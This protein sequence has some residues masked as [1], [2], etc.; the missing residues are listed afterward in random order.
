LFTGGG[1]WI[2]SGDW[3]DETAPKAYLNYILFDENF[4]LVDFGFDQVS[5]AAASGHEYIGLHVKVQQKGYLYVYLSNE[6]AVQTN[7]Y[8]D[9]FEILYHSAVEQV[10]DYYPFGYRS[11]YL[12]V[13]KG[14]LM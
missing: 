9:D 8:F 11:K 4:V 10:D 7:V 12:F 5:T 1:P 3:E 13:R 14:S 2:G 6:Q